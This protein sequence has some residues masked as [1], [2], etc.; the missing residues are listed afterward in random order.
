MTQIWPGPK[1]SFGFSPLKRATTK[2]AN[3][4]EGPNP[5]RPYYIPPSIG[6]PPE[7]A[8]SSGARGHGI[9]NGSA[10]SYA[11]SARDIFPDIDY[12]DY[13]S[14]STPS[15]VGM[16][17]NLLDQ[18]LYKYTSVLLAQ[19]FEVAKTVLQVR[20]QGV[21]TDEIP[22]AGVDDRRPQSSSY[23]DSIYSDVC[24]TDEIL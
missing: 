4:R 14:D 10:A 7:I 18:A 6:V 1:I 19:P 13:L 11:S 8:T 2:M 17:K 24:S 16:I 22:V 9:K 21:V 12:G 3:S 15:S 5:L 20:N 23:R